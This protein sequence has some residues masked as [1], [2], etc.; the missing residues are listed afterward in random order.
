MQ[1]RYSRP[2]HTHSEQHTLCPYFDVNG[3]QLFTGKS[4]S[5][6]GS[7]L[8]GLKVQQLYYSKAK[9]FT[10][11]RGISQ[12]KLMFP[13]NFLRGVSVALFSTAWTFCFWAQMS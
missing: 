4:I 11:I 7:C 9:F 13:I 3:R 12:G 6:A 8:L 5:E 2:S 1:I 10:C